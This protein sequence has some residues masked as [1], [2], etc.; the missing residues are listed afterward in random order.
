MSTGDDGDEVAEL[1]A[2]LKELKERTARSYGSLARRLGMNTSTLHRYCAGE[3]VPQDFAPVERLAEFSGATPEERLELHRRWLRAVAVRQT[4]RPRTATTA[5]PEAAAPRSAEPG[6]ADPEAAA[7]EAGPA[8]ATAGRRSGGRWGR[9]AGR[10]ARPALAPASADRT[11]RRRH[12][13]AARDTRHPVRAPG[14]PLLVGPLALDVVLGGHV[15][16]RTRP[17]D[18][19][20][21]PRPS[22]TASAN[23]SSSPSP[24]PGG[25]SPTPRTPEPSTPAGTAP[26]DTT[27][28]LTWTA[29]SRAWALGSGHDYV[30]A[31]PPARV[32]PPPAA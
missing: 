5:E 15:R 1:A 32:P 12:L 27:V 24:T 26:G 28:P 20:A 10:R 9:R 19:P 3:V 22:S 18:G 6:T 7:A 23:P 21:A 29:D 13:R 4:A 25:A 30:V 14:R 11:A 8:D 31:Q 2:L 17:Y 16:P